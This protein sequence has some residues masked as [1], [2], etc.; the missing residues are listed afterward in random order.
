[1]AR[2]RPE[3]TERRTR[4]R[5]ARQLVRDR[6]KL[7]RLVAGGA[8]EHPLEVPS[9]AVIEIRARAMPCAQCEGEYKVIE[10]R[11]DGAG[12][13]AVDVAC[14]RCGVKRTLWFRIASDDPN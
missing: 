9:S 14:Q 10:H 1:M 3:R 7:A 5:A 4:E 11:A 2:K 6:E 8:R 13:R 12:V